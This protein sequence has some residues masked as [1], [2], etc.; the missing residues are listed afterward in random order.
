MK[1]YIYIS[2]TQ[3]INGVKLGFTRCPYCRLKSYKNPSNPSFKYNSLYEFDDI[4]IAYSIE[5]HFHRF[6]LNKTIIDNVICKEW[7]KFDEI[8]IKEQLIKLINNYHNQY[9]FNFT[10][11][12]VNN[13]C[14]CNETLTY[15]REIELNKSVD[16]KNVYSFNCHLVLNNYQKQ[17]L[18]NWT[19]N[20]NE[21]KNGLFVMATGSGKTITALFAILKYLQ[22][23]LNKNILWVTRFKDTFNSQLNDFKSIGIEYQ[24]CDAKTSLDNKINIMSNSLLVN[25]VK[26][27]ELFENIGLIVVDECHNL[28]GDSTFDSIM[29][30][31]HIHK[32][33]IIGFSATPFYEKSC[34]LYSRLNLLFNEYPITLTLPQVIE[35]SNA[36]KFNINYFYNLS[37]IK[38]EKKKVLIYYSKSD[39][40]QVQTIIDHLEVQKIDNPELNDINVLVS[41][42]SETD[43]IYG[44]PDGENL[45][46]FMN[47]KYCY[48]LVIDRF[49]QGTNDPSIDYIIDAT[50][51]DHE[52]HT[53]I[54]MLGRL[55]RFPIDLPKDKKSAY[56]KNYYRYINTEASESKITDNDINKIINYLKILDNNI[57]TIYSHELGRLVIKYNSN[58]IGTCSYYIKMSD[59]LKLVFNKTMLKLQITYEEFQ[60]LFKSCKNENDYISLCRSLGI[61][62][63][64]DWYLKFKYDRPEINFK[65]VFKWHELYT[66]SILDHPSFVTYCR[67]NKIDYI[68]GL[69]NTS[70]WESEHEKNKHIPED[71]IECYNILT[72][73]KPRFCYNIS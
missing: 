63:K 2:Q 67:N 55:M 62:S 26:Q 25:L 11:I 28:N 8:S 19:C 34:K 22:I 32:C 31:I 12:D 45:S 42:S 4:N 20:D 24:I 39:K 21:I 17:A 57:Y 56:E 1:G 52:S 40:D 27:K 14:V 5:Q 23:R 18:Q 49:K 13:E 72:N 30:L 66:Q 64:K 10:L 43:I 70:I 73:L 35:D 61:Y 15:D 33:N 41:R 47:S 29:S 16:I 6:N 65:P 68:N 54:Q 3:T 58:V 59:N 60:I 38:L 7:Y 69:Q 71:P 37:D 48:L 36:P 50:C 53:F 9:K 51:A 44:D 46:K